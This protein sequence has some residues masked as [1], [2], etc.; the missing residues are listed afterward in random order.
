MKIL[1]ITAYFDDY[2]TINVDKNFSL[3]IR[4]GETQI[5]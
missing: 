4:V 5:F 1:K 2:F 3:Q